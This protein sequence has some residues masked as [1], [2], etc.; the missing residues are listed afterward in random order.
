MTAGAG[1]TFDLPYLI[2]C[3]G[4]DDCCYFNALIN[5]RALRRCCIHHTGRSRHARGGKFLFGDSLRA[6][7]VARTWRNIRKILLVVDCDDNQTASFD[8]VCDQVE[9]VFDKRPAALGSPLNIDGTRLLAI[10]TTPFAGQTGHLETLCATAARAADAAVAGHTSHFAAM[11]GVDGWG[12]ALREEEM[13]LR[14]NL[15]ARNQAHPAI[16]LGN[17][18]SEAPALIPLGNAA[19]NDHANFLASFFP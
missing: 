5:A 8:T 19:F 9:R 16:H 17:A 2:I 14:A 11:A 6:A 15:A 4:Y 13:W 3:E 7:R 12:N 18:F 1:W 10:I